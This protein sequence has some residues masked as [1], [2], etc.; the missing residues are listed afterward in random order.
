MLIYRR[1]TQLRVRALAAIACLSAITACSGADGVD[2]VDE[3]LVTVTDTELSS[4]STIAGDRRPTATDEP[5]SMAAFRVD[6]TLASD[7]VGVDTEIGVDVDPGAL[8]LTDP[9][10]TFASC[11]GVRRAFGPY[12][13]QISVSS[14]E[15]LAA[16]VSTSQAVTSAGIHD[17][18]LRLE[19]DSGE[20]VSAA[21]T[22]TIAAGWRSGSFL[23]FTVG[24]GSVSGTFTCSGGD[25]DPA[26]L[27]ITSGVDRS[28]VVEVA[29]LLRRGQAERVVD[30][31]LDLSRSPQTYA[32][33]A[34]GDGQQGE[35]VVR[36]DGDQTLGAID[37]FELTGGDRPTMRLRVGGASYVFD[38]VDLTLADPA[39]SG[40]FSATADGTSVDGAFRCS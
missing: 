25:P 15:V 4:T 14:G 10:G 6:M 27:S 34:G 35:Y 21:G 18:D 37:T 2:E 23:A 11:S 38:D 19:L 33:C 3:E 22:V 7:S 28:G 16:A 24:G 40:T 31:A 32:E 17:A 8:E 20:V 13:V 39:T 29:A 36:V 9:F 1:R 5:G 12:S 26:P 30:L